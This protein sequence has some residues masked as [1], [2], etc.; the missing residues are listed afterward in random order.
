VPRRIGVL[1]GVV[2]RIAVPVQLLRVLWPIS[3]GAPG[4][5]SRWAA[6]PDR[7]RAAAGHNGVGGDEAADGRIVIP[8][9]IEQCPPARLS[10]KGAAPSRP[11]ERE[12]RARQDAECGQ[13]TIPRGIGRR[14]RRLLKHSDP[15]QM[16]TVV[17]VLIAYIDSAK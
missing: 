17:P 1:D 2:Q 14:G 3:A 15:A 12:R 8:G 6:R 13:C 7:E 9:S 4:A 10:W 5:L 11:S 16:F